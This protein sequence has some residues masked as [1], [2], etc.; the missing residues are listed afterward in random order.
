MYIHTTMYNIYIKIY[1]IWY[2][3]INI[4]DIYKYI[5]ISMLILI[6]NFDILIY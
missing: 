4:H 5:N 2:I 1:H 3:I 6:Y